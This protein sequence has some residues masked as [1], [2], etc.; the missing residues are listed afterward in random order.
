MENIIVDIIGW[1]GTAMLL[2]GYYLNAKKYDVSW[3]AWFVGNI[4]MLVYS[5]CIVAWPQVILAI[6]LLCMN[7]YGY[8]S[9]KK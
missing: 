6:V 5:Y 4:L 8:I 1:S 7:I 2:M 9:W 3:I